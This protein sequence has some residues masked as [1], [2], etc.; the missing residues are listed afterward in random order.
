M[1]DGKLLYELGHFAEA[2]S[3]LQLLLAET[4]DPHVRTS[5]SYYLDRIDRGLA[6]ETDSTGLRCFGP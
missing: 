3:C 2:R 6:P 1:Q 4:S 5:A